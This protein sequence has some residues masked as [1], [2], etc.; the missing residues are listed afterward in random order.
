M[1]QPRSRT[2]TFIIPTTC[3]PSTAER[4]PLLRARAQISL[5]G[6]TTPVTVVMWLTNTTR[7]RGVMASATRERTSAALAGGRGSSNFLTTMP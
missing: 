4:I 7:V 3:A 2:S 5:T 1:S 6:S